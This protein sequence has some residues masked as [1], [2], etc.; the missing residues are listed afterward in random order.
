M[1]MEELMMEINKKLR[2]ECDEAIA[3]RENPRLITLM[4]TLIRMTN[5]EED[6][7]ALDAVEGKA[8]AHKEPTEAEI[9]A[10]FKAGKLK[11]V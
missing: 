2:E 6:N 11:A 7:E 1:S 9:I 10:A 3:H 4:Q 8:A 5:S